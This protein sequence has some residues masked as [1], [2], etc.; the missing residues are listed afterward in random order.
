MTQQCRY[1]QTLGRVILLFVMA[2]LWARPLAAQTEIKIMIN[3]PFDYMVDPRNPTRIV[4]MAA[5]STYHTPVQIFS[6]DNAAAPPTTGLQTLQLGVFSMDFTGHIPHTGPLPVTPIVYQVGNQIDVKVIDDAVYKPTMP[7]YALSLPKPDYYTTFYGSFGT[8]RWTGLSQSIISASQITSTAVV[9]DARA[10]DYTTW[11]VLHYSVSA[12]P[13]SATLTGKRDDG[14]PFPQQSIKFSSFSAQTPIKAISIV[15]MGLPDL[16]N[17]PKCDTYSHDSFKHS[18]DLWHL[19]LY[20]LFPQLDGQGANSNQVHDV[21]NYDCTYV[22][23]SSP[24]K[25]GPGRT[26]SSLEQHI[27]SAG[28]ADCHMAQIS[29]NDVVANK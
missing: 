26:K 8:A 4:V 27:E 5:K 15:Q 11:M 6:G 28:S 23:V 24:R 16:G 1:W 25:S 7:R 10:E 3:G 9:P 2:T 29:L 14:T 21:F 12:A 22:A 20:A 13:S 18:N 19:G 17:D